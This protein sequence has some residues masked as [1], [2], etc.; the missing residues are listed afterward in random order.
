MSRFWIGIGF[1]AVLLATGLWVSAAMNEIAEPVAQKLTQAGELA[2]QGDMEQALETA[3]R[4]GMDWRSHWRVVAAF[5]DHS[6]MEEID[7]RLAELEVYGREGEQ[8]D[9]AAACAAAARQVEAV[10][11]AHKPCWWNLV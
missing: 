3:Q 7:S 4:A 1:L 6:P 10:A 11:Q 9:F 5:A 8:T 2:L